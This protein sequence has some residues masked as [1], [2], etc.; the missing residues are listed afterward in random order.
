MGHVLPCSNAVAG[1]GREGG[2][3]RGTDCTAQ[4]ASLAW[5][6]G[7]KAVKGTLGHLGSAGCSEWLWKVLSKLGMGL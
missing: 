6:Y 7:Q 5:L 3:G 2:C 4:W 1:V